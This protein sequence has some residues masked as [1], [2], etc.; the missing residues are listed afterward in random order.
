MSDRTHFHTDCRIPL[1]SERYGWRT[2]VEPTIP[3]ARRHNAADAIPWGWRQRAYHHDHL[4][5]GLDN[6]CRLYPNLFRASG[7]G[8][9]WWMMRKQQ[10]NGVGKGQSMWRMVKD[11]LYKIDAEKDAGDSVHLERCSSA[12]WLGTRENEAAGP[13]TA[14]TNQQ[15]PAGGR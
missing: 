14:P 2:G 3:R 10:K 11:I 7:P 13:R 6:T 9:H 15:Q 5:K 1:K 4:G 8:Y 12:D